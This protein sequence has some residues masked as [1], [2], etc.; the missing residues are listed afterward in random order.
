MLSTLPV[1]VELLT[2]IGD[3]N[4]RPRYVVDSFI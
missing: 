3:F 4:F 2:M 1:N